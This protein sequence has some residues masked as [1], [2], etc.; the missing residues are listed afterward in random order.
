MS[1]SWDCTYPVGQ[2]KAKIIFQQ[3]REP[4]LSEILVV[5]QIVED[6]FRKP[7]KI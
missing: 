2:G 7:C 1:G 6:K 3:P 5:S 4:S